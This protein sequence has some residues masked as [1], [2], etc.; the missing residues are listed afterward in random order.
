MRGEATL[1]EKWRNVIRLKKIDCSIKKILTSKARREAKCNL[2]KIFRMEEISWGEKS[3]VLWLKERY[4]NSKF[5]HQMANV[6]RK[7]NF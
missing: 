5:F 1:K 4:K 3:K 6:R 7:I 2:W